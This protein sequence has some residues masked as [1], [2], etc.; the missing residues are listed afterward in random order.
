MPNDDPTQTADPS[1]MYRWRNVTC[2]HSAPDA[3]MRAIDALED[4]LDPLPP[5]V[6]RIRA[7]ISRVDPLSHYKAFENVAFL[8][9]AIGALDYP[10]SP[11]VDVLWRHGEIDD[12]R[13]AE[14]RCYVHALDAWLGDATEA[15]ARQAHPDCTAAIEATYAALGE[16]DD[17]KRWLAMSLKKT[18]KEHAFLP[19]DVIAEHDDAAFVRAVYKAVLG[20]PPSPDDLQF[21]VEELAGGKTRAAFLEEIL[22][23]EEHQRRHL[24]EVADLL[25]HA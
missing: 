18:L 7:L 8:L 9:D 13:R 19:W 3:E 22:S 2:P 23:A 4:R 20:R 17:N 6:E 24:H 10:G 12:A 16:A 15:A 21:R 11:A 5:K 25:K 1:R 14:A